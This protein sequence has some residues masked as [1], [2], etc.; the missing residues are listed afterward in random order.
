MSE[1]QEE[2]RQCEAAKR[3]ADRDLRFSRITGLWALGLVVSMGCEEPNLIR[4]PDFG[5]P[6]LGTPDLGWDG[7]TPDLGSLPQVDVGFPPTDAGVPVAE[8]PVYIHTG[9]TLY[10]YDSDT[11]AAIE[12]GEFRDADGP[13]DN[14]V[15]IAINRDGLMYG[16]R[17]GR[18]DEFPRD[19]VL[20]D[21]ETA[22][23]RYLFGFDDELNGLT[24]LPDGR[25]V[26][27]GQRVSVLDPNTGALL[28]EYS[29]ANAFETSG[30]IVGLPDGLLYWT[31]RA[32]EGEAPG[33]R[34]VRIDPATGRATLLSKLAV[35]RIFGLGFADDTLFGFSRTGVVVAIDPQ[36]GFT[37]LE[38]PLSGAW[39]GATTNPVV[40][41]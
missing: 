10:S 25:L 41:D 8:E 31:V 38:S 20:I 3:S 36:S 1:R 15:D 12:V 28:V 4:V 7:G 27:A 16:G 21:P 26:V 37:V 40:W 23:C 24:F 11:N 2:P 32:A 29:S 19:I 30:D 35:D 17:G 34:V 39:F 33:D 14:I 6:D 22:F 5:V 13:I 9:T 18:R